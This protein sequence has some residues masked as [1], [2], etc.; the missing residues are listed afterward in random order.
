M[1]TSNIKPSSIFCKKSGYGQ[2][3][4]ILR[5]VNLTVFMSLI[6]LS[7]FFDGFREKTPALYPGI[8][9][10]SREWLQTLEGSDAGSLLSVAVAWSEGKSL[11]DS[12]LDWILNLWT[13]GL[14]LLETVFLKVLGVGAPIYFLVLV[15]SIIVW[16]FVVDIV[17]QELSKFFSVAISITLISVFSLSGDFKF[18]IQNPLNPEGI[19]VGLLVLSL[20]LFMRTAR[21]AYS[22]FGHLFSGSLLGLSIIFRSAFDYILVFCFVFSLIIIIFKWRKINS[23]QITEKELRIQGQNKLLNSVLN[24]LSHPALIYSLSAFVL[25]LPWRI[26][27]FV[28]RGTSNLQMT[29]ASSLLPQNLWFESSSFMGKYWDQQGMNWACDISPKKCLEFN[30]TSYDFNGSKTYLLIE[31]IKSVILNPLEYVSVRFEA[32]QQNWIYSDNPSLFQFFVLTVPSILLIFYFMRMRKKLIYLDISQKIVILS[33]LA[34]IGLPFFFI[35]FE[36]RYFI[37]L[38]MIILVLLMFLLSIWKNSDS[39]SWFIHKNAICETKSIGDG[40]RIWAFTHILTNAQ[41]G[42]D[43]NI[44]DFVFIENDVRI[45]DRVT[46]KSGVQVWDQTLIED[47]VFIG[48]NVTFTNDKYPRSKAEFNR[49]LQIVIKNRATIGAGAIILPGVVVGEDSFIG[50]GA[51]VTKNVKSG[52][53]VIGNPAKDVGPAPNIKRSIEFEKSNHQKSKD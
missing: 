17:F 29:S 22:K 2:P 26:F 46:I 31:A 7:L 4:V 40:T 25:T 19:S 20:L 5:V 44:C 13:P 45:G 3:N 43:C 53:L 35:H 33:F 42:R 6:C 14:P 51:V 28:A 47:D 21:K 18:M 32:L 11:Q 41:I 48:P 50:A 16:L 24:A 39:N 23:S 1:K 38:R 10:G 37:P 8:F 49:S 9:A 34:G 27:T 30:V 12:G 36:S 52:R 15:V